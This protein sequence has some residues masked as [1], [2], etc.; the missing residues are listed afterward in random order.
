MPKKIILKNLVN[1]QGRALSVSVPDNLTEKELQ[2]ICAAGVKAGKEFKKAFK[3]SGE[4][5]VFKDAEE[6][7]AAARSALEKVKQIFSNKS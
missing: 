4:L 5:R 6:V 3:T 2:E 7:R 1:E